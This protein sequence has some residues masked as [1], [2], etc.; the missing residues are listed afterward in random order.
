MEAIQDRPLARSARPLREVWPFLKRYRWRLAGAIVFLLAGAAATL[1]LPI[2]VRQMIDLGFGVENAE[3]ID[4]Y[5]L[6]F[7]LIAAIMALAVGMRY[8]FV[9]WIGERIVADLRDAVYRRVIAMSPAFF[10]VT[11]TGEVL[12]RLNTDTTLVQT[13]V[14]SSASIALRSALMLVGAGALLVLTSPKLAGLMALVIP[15][16]V[17]PIVF[18]GRWVRRLSRQSQDGIADFSALAGETLNA[19]PT[20]QA[21]NQGEREASRFGAAVDRAFRLAIRRTLAT[22]AMS[23]SITLL[24]FG[25]IVLVLWVG[26]KAVIAGTM[27]AG[28]LSQ[29][30]LYALIAAGSSGALTEVWGDVQRAAGAME[31]IAELLASRSAIASPAVPRPMPTPAR[32]EIHFDAVSF[33][34]PSRPDTDVLRELSCVIEAG[35]TVA[36]VGPSGAGKSTIFQL[37]LRFYD[38]RTGAIRID[39]VDLR[40][41]DPDAFRSRI[42]VVPQDTVIFSANALENIRYGRPDADEGAVITAACAA[43]A[44]DF[45]VDLA[46]GYETFLGERGVRLSGGQ[47]QR[48]AIARALLRDPPILLLD[49]ATSALDAESERQIQAAIEEISATRTTLIIA[50]RLATVRHA[51]R[52]LVLD[53][54]RLAAAGTHDELIAANPLYAHLAKLQFAA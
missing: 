35:E 8:Y 27:T 7:F 37:L 24:V 31:R 29:F 22:A 33:A 18:F 40:D 34:Y 41:A 38:P 5:F 13:V 17:L 15:L 23:I 44:H 36:L 39:G 50:H 2:A 43:H 46:E 42:A 25:A 52:I 28:E 32:G 48:L 12:S 14:G 47:R 16:V 21:F 49:E 20:V 26:A 54:G 6:A 11:R 4:R 51:D 45:I 9:T 30:I 19:V 10:E 3:A 53:Q 1:V